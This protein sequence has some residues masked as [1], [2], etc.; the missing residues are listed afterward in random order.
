MQDTCY[1]PKVQAAFVG[2]KR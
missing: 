1:V 2:L